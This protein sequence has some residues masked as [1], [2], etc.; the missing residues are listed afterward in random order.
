MLERV[1]H[2]PPRPVS[3]GY[4]IVI[5]EPRQKQQNGGETT[6]QKGS[7]YSL[8][9]IAERDLPL[10][11]YNLSTTTKGRTRSRD[12]VTQSLLIRLTGEPV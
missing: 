4:D 1:Q 3:C 10:P 6:S 12:I 11:N 5:V 7:M 2:S 8:L 9:H